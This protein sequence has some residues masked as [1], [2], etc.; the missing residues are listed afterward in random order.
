MFYL[1]LKADLIL[2]LFSPLFGMSGN[3]KNGKTV[4]I[5]RCDETVRV[6]L[7]MRNYF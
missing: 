7:L 1:L 6:Q 4:L 3:I 5:M 2:D